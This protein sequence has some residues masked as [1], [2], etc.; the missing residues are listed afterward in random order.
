MPDA[1]LLLMYEQHMY[2]THT[3]TQLDSI[4][5]WWGIDTLSPCDVFL[6]NNI[7]S[8][9]DF[10]APHHTGFES[11]L[12]VKQNLCLGLFIL[13]LLQHSYY[14][15]SMKEGIFVDKRKLRLAFAS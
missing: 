11:F 9:E 2:I 5:Y 4:T 12:L 15:F 3:A 14:T 10:L 1:Y 8:S 7:S 6:S 13:S